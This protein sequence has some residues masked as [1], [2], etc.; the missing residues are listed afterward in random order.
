MTKNGVIK[1]QIEDLK[2]DVDSLKTDVKAIMENHLPHIKTGLESLKTRI[3]TQTV[4]QVGAIIIGAV[5]L[6]YL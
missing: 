5:I 1:F 4:I 3:N 2:C 6:K